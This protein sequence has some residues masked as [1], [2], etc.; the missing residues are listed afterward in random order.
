MRDLRPA[1]ARPAAAGFS[2]P[3]PAA[4]VAG[5]AFA[6]RRLPALRRSSDCPAVG[7]CGPPRPSTAG[8][9]GDTAAAGTGRETIRFARPHGVFHEPGR[10]LYV[11]DSEAHRIGCT[12][13]LLGNVVEGV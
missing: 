12:S 13:D 10:G 9:V 4:A 5:A 11:G 1:T 7:P 3:L 8:G 2:E 6:P